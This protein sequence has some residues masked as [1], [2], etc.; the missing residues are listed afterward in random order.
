MKN[1]MNPAVF[2]MGFNFIFFRKT[3]IKKR[4]LYNDAA[5]NKSPVKTGRDM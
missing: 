2:R 4:H 5:G 1:A 3:G